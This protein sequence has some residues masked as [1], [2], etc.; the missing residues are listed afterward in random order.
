ML[1]TAK[2]IGVMVTRGAYGALRLG[3]I[4]FVVVNSTSGLLT[5]DHATVTLRLHIGMDGTYSSTSPTYITAAAAS[6]LR[7]EEKAPD[8]TENIDSFWT[9]DGKESASA[10]PITLSTKAAPDIIALSSEVGLEDRLLQFC[11]LD[12]RKAQ[13]QGILMAKRVTLAIIIQL[14]VYEYGATGCSAGTSI[15]DSTWELPVTFV[16]LKPEGVPP[17]ARP[18]LAAQ[19]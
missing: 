4:D 13:T 8:T 3:S 11:E 10:E 14:L 9:V 12:S 1:D 6:G 19:D 5:L 15:D 7:L 16:C 18:P 2:P 17:S